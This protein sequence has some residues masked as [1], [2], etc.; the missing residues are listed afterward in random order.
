MPSQWSEAYRRKIEI[1]LCKSLKFVE[2]RRPTEDTAR[3]GGDGRSLSDAGQMPPAHYE[4]VT[5]LLK[6]GANSINF[7][8]LD[9]TIRPCGRR[10]R[11][12]TRWIATVEPWPIDRDQ[13]WYRR[14]LLS[15][16]IAADFVLNQRRARCWKF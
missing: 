12:L 2:Q 8:L 5:E 14:L 10:T 9:Q 4:M 15:A 6:I 11:V 13:G 1:P 3:D 7:V 16:G